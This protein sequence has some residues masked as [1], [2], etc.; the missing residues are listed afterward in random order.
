MCN[1]KDKSCW[2]IAIDTEMSSLI[3]KTI[4][5]TAT[6]R[7][8]IRENIR[9]LTTVSILLNASYN[10]RNDITSLT[11][12]NR[13]IYSD[14]LFFNIVFIM[15]CRIANSSTSTLNRRKLCVRCTLTSSTYCNKDI[16]YLCSYFF[17]WELISNCPLRNT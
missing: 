1:T 5:L 9:H 14:I 16:L 7:T 13:I 4:Q 10:L 3:F 15:K 12:N 2:T 8:C 6:H 11:H 17:C